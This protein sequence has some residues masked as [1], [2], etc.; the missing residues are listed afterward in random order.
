MADQPPPLPPSTYPPP[1]PGQVYG[2]PPGQAPAQQRS[3][4]SRNWGW[5]LGCGCLSV[6]VGGALVV[7]LIVMLVFSA[8]KSTDVYKASLQQVQNSPAAQQQLGTP[9]VDSYYVGGNVN[10]QNN[11]GAAD[12]QFPVSGPKGSGTVKVKATL[13]NGRWSI[14]SLVLEVNGQPAPV[15]II[16]PGV[17]ES[18]D[19]SKTVKLDERGVKAVA[20]QSYL[21]HPVNSANCRA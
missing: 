12:L 4:F 5:L 7:L 10:I 3:W 8:I 18:P 17:L 13:T 19:P 20:F 2:Q 6:L 16:G 21:S 9:I 15:L 1:P 14:T 11:S